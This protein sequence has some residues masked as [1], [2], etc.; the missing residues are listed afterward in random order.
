MMM[1][2]KPNKSRWQLKQELAAPSRFYGDDGTIHHTTTLDVETRNGKVVAVWFRC[3]AIAFKQS[4]VDKDRA[5]EMW[6][7]PGSMITGVQVS[8]D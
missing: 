7:M 3:Q 4:E 1:W 2:R 8:D 6:S 5:A